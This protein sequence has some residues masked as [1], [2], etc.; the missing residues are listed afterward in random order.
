MLLKSAFPTIEVMYSEDWKDFSDMRLPYVLERVV[1]ADRGAADRN[2]IDW[3]VK[4]SPDLAGPGI[5]VGDELRKRQS[6]SNEDDLPAWAASVVGYNMPEGW[7]TPVRGALL[8]YL[9]LPVERQ[10]RAK[11][12]VTFVSMQ[13]EPYE[14]GAHVRTE[15]HPGLVDGLRK[16]EREGVI[17]EFHVLRGNGTKEDWEQRMKIVSRTDVSWHNV[18]IQCVLI[19]LC[20]D[21]A[22]RIWTQPGRQLV[23]AC[24][25][26]RLGDDYPCAFAHGVL[27]LRNIPE[28]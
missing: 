2:R 21:H 7:W 13:E 5:G 25:Y 27:S 18:H 28:R 4:W 20:S 12:V 14:A 8:K 3:G 26:T 19:V 24:A 9:G 10:K 17:S 6:S 15:D 11:P 1:I 22:R 16:L 23:L